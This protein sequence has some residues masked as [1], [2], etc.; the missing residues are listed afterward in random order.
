MKP[1][2]PPVRRRMFGKNFVGPMVPRR[3]RE[4]TN[5]DICSIEGR[6]DPG[7]GRTTIAEGCT[8]GR[9]VETGDEISGRP[10]P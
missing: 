6:A 2:E 4:R 8:G 9:I 10:R 7:D 1:S 3:V 5:E